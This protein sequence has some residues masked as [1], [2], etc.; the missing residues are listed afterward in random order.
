[1]EAVVGAVLVQERLV[2]VG[3]EIEVV[4]QLVMDDAERVLRR[5]DA[6][7]DA[8]V[9]EVV[10]VPRAGVTHH[11]PVPGSLEQRALPE[12]RRERIEAE[13]RVEPLAHADHLDGGDA[14]RLENRADVRPGGCSRRAGHYQ[15]RDVAPVLAPQVAEQMYGEHAVGRDAGGAVARH[16]PAA[17]V[18]VELQVERA[19]LLPQPVHDG[20]EGVGRHV[21]PGA[22]HGPRVGEPHVPRAGVRERDEARVAVAHGNA[23]RLPAG[24]R[25]EQRVG[26]ARSGEHV[27]EVVQVP[28]HGLPACARLA[29]LGASVVGVEAGAEP[30]HL[31]GFRR[32]GGRRGREL[33]LE[34]QQATLHIGRQRCSV[35]RP[36]PV[37]QPLERRGEVGLRVGGQELG[38]VGNEVLAHPAGA[39]R[40]DILDRQLVL[41]GIEKPSRGGDRGVGSLGE[42]E[43]D[44]EEML[45]AHTIGWR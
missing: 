28:A 40:R 30:R 21:V 32:I 44:E 12:R 20:D 4:P 27:L 35:E 15:V 33:E 11:V 1:M 2:L 17:H 5:L 39:A 6:H 23:D 8:Q 24:P 29:V 41:G 45:H 14:P 26:I 38:I 31:R 3:A 22:P 43:N 9:G 25:V 18:R 16:Q 19:D 34:Q 42:G 10:D 36:R 13:R 37:H 7:L